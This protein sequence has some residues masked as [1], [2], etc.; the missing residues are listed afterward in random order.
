M[1][2]AI[3][4]AGGLGERL[5][6][7]T[8]ECPKAMVE[9]LGRPIMAYQ[10]HWLRSHGVSQVVVSCGH[11]HE[12]ISDYFADGSK[13]QVNITYEIENEPL[14]RG[15]GLK[16]ALKHW[17]DLNEPVLALNGDTFTNLDIGELVKFHAAHFPLATVVTVPLRTDYGIVD[18]DT[19][20]TVVGFREKP[21]LPYEVNAGV[22]VLSPDI[23]GLLPDK[24]DHEVET[25]PELARKG[26]LKA[27]RHPG[28][29]RAVDTAKDLAELR[30]EM[31]QLLLDS[32]FQ[33]G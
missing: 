18:V 21:E 23:A 32:V 30:R 5:R 29:W 6:P 13:W 28:Y 9:V 12:V 16:Q 1:K 10:M 27:F 14:G 8:E 15:G 4:L 7:L 19:E 20:Q 22:Y 31:E 11:R 24:G 26:K 3:I 17:S 25:F 2:R 33:P